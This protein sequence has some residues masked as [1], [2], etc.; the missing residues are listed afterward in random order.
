MKAFRQAFHGFIFAFLLAFGFLPTAQAAEPI[1]VR[2]LI[3][4]DP[5]GQFRRAAEVFA[6]ELNKESKGELKL[7]VRFP[8]HFGLKD[9]FVDVAESRKL[10]EA[11]KVEL[12]QATL[13]GMADIE[14]DFYVFD[15]PFLFR[16]YAHINKVLE[17]NV[18]QRLLASLDEKNLAGLAFTF[19]G[20]F[21]VISSQKRSVTSPEAFAAMKIRTTNSPASLETFHALGANPVSLFVSDQ[22]AAMEENRIDGVESAYARLDAYLGDNCKYITLTNHSVFLTAIIANKS[23]IASLTPSQQQALKNAAIKAA[24]VER[25]DSLRSGDETLERLKQRGIKVVALTKSQ[26][27][28]LEAHT[29]SVYGKLVPTLFNPSLIDEIR[30]AGKP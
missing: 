11:G 2:W 26:R 28:K 4:H 16:S 18:G 12:S 9:G 13:N 19:S 24:R 20:G 10:F 1:K 29:A 14:P 21:R 27:Q 30:D 6:S 22:K 23:F 8:R 17:G 15:L 25:V 3:A 7:E 5:I